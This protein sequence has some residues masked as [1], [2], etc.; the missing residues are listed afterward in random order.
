ML[1]TRSRPP[2]ARVCA[3]RRDSS[4]SG[5]RLRG[6]AFCAR[7]DQGKVKALEAPCCSCSLSQELKRNRNLP[8]H[9]VSRDKGIS[10]SPLKRPACQSTSTTQSEA[11]HDV[12]SYTQARAERRFLNVPGSPGDVRHTTAH[13]LTC[14]ARTIFTSHRCLCA[15]SLVSIGTRGVPHVEVKSAWPCITGSSKPGG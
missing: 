4:T 2:T 11:R 10:I 5:S 13:H 14:Q 8:C 6:R 12:V 1:R 7:T 9:A 3:G 15:N